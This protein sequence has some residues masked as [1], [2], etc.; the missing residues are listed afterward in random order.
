MYK[1]SAIQKVGYNFVNFFFQNNF[2]N[3]IYNILKKKNQE[4][5]LMFLI[6]VVILEIFLESLKKN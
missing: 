1:K 4:K 3:D 6:S 5:K 2:T